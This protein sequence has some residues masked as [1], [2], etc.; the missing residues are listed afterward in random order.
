[1][2][3]NKRDK[4]DD[5]SEISFCILTETAGLALGLEQAED[6]VNADWKR[7]KALLVSG[8]EMGFASRLWI[9]PRNFL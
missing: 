6:V 7:G 4:I 3:E 5:A 8:S 9:D 1:M 2:R